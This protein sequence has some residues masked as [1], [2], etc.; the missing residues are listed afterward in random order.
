MESYFDIQVEELRRQV[1]KFRK[2]YSMVSQKTEKLIVTIPE[3]FKVEFF[4]LVDK[5]NFSLLEDNDNFFGYFLFQMG[6]D[7]RFDI[8]SPTGVNFIG[9]KYII[10]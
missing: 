9:T 5:V 10:Y 1:K 8:S 3:E 7:I 2:S 4:S 6:R